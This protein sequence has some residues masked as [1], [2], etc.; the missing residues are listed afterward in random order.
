VNVVLSKTNMICFF[1]QML[2]LSFSVAQIKVTQCTQDHEEPQII[3]TLGK[4]DYFGEKALIRCCP[5]S[6]PSSMS[7][8]NPISI[9]IWYMGTFSITAVAESI[10]FVSSTCILVNRVLQTY[11]LPQHVQLSFLGAIFSSVYV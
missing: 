7:P 10:I 6:I 8:F 9:P 1:F 3:N 2:P 4:G 5:S 11:S